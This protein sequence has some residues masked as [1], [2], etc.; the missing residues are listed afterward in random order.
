MRDLLRGG[1]W[2][3][4]VAVALV[5]TA[6]TASN[7]AP[8]FPTVVGQN[9]SGRTMTLPADF[10]AP[11]SIVFIAYAREQQ[12]DVDSW[13][14]LTA[15]VKRRFP[16]IGVYEVPTLPKGD[17]FFRWFID[18]G[19]RRGIPDTAT[20]DVTITLYIDKKPFNDAL[21][22][23]SEKEI[24]LLLVTPS[25]TLLWRTTGTYTVAKAAELIEAIIGLDASK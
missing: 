22:I 14:P 7:A 13:K 6:A 2:S 24:T 5:G 21:T 3:L 16:A 8:M 18:G 12:M 15:D 20:R 10:R 23:R 17:A 25:G 4:I 1:V 19:M 9:L 11:A